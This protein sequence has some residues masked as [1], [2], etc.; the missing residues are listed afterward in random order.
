MTLPTLANVISFCHKLSLAYDNKN[1]LIS[2]EIKNNYA[3]EFINSIDI[4]KIDSNEAF[5][6]FMLN[7]YKLLNEIISMI[8]EENPENA[9][10]LYLA[11]ASQINRIQSDKNNFEEACAS[12]MNAAGNIPRGKI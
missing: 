4:S 11:S 5:Y 6:N 3:N 12:F 2:E 9:F 8:A 7:D 10:R 1:N